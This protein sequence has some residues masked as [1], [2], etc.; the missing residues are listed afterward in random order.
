[1]GARDR[2]ER[3]GRRALGEVLR[4]VRVP[5]L[6]SGAR[7]AETIEGVDADEPLDARLHV[8]G[9]GLVGGGHVGPFGV[10]ADLRYG[11][12][13]ED[14]VG[15]RP[16][17]IGMVRVPVAA[18]VGDADVL[19]VH[20]LGREDQHFG[21]VL[22]LVLRVDVVLDLAE[23]PRE[24]GLLRGIERLAAHR[25]HLVCVQRVAETQERGLVH[26]RG[27]DSGHLRAH[28][29]RQRRDRHRSRGGLRL[30][31]GFGC[32][33]CHGAPP[34]AAGLAPGRAFTED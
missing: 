23:A 33:G 16:V 27:I 7:V 1:M 14:G 3:V 21:L 18:G 8:V 30:I 11:D 4:G 24:R 12:R 9:Q 32:L 28:G 5:G 29:G 22:H 34:A 20:H 26:G 13:L 2:M 25:Q 10:A 31:D 19:A 15:G 17:D 6:L